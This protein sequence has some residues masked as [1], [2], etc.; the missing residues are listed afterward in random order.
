MPRDAIVSAE[1]LWY[2][3]GAGVAGGLI[4]GVGMGIILHAGANVMLFIGALYGWPTVLG[5]WVAHIANSVLIGLVFALLVSRSII[6]QETP[7]TLEYVI[8]GIIYAAVVGLVTT[9]VMLPITVN[10]LDR[11]PFPEPLLPLPGI[12]GGML[13]VLSVGVAHVVYGVLLGATYGAIHTRGSE[14]DTVE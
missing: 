2:T 8:D 1:A 7:T 14:I 5:G 13:V 11:E 9:G 6:R 4:G 10:L 3:W 12:V